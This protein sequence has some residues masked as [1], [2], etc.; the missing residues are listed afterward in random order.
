MRSILLSA[1]AAASLIMMAPAMAHAQAASKTPCDIPDPIATGANAEAQARAAI[2]AEKPYC[3]GAIG[4][5]GSVLAPEPAPIAVDASATVDPSPPTVSTVTTYEPIAPQPAT[6]TNQLVTNGPVPDT[7]ENRAKY[8][9]PMSNA[10][11]RTAP[12]GN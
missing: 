3:A 12:A 2:A 6:Y 9:A 10:G 1:A 5:S 11:K 4:I 7:L 8:G